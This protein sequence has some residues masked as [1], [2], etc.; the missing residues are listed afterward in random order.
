MCLKNVF[1]LLR[2]FL[3]RTFVPKTERSSRVPS[4]FLHRLKCHQLNDFTAT[5]CCLCRFSLLWIY[6]IFT[7]LFGVICIRCNLAQLRGF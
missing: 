5:K 2:M 7:V 1:G 6:L 3:N 4:L